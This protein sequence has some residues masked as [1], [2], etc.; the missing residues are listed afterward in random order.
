[1]ITFRTDEETEYAL[2]VLTLDG[3]SRS[4]AIRQAVLDQIDLIDL[5]PRI[6]ILARAAEPSTVRSLDA[7]HLGTA[8]HS[9]PGLTSFV[10]MTNGSWT[11]RRRQVYPSTR[12]PDRSRR[13][14]HRAKRRLWLVGP[15]ASAA[16]AGHHAWSAAPWTRGFHLSLRGGA[17]ATRT[18]TW[19]RS[20]EL[21]PAALTAD[22]RGTSA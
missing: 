12:P 18:R 16:S 14:R 3:S 19:P 9:R 11:R 8:L 20:G 2:D 4:A 15:P 17:P 7:V 10:T 1:M 13:Y 21:V 5:D 22:H 6:R